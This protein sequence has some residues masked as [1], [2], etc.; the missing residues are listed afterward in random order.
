MGARLAGLMLLGLAMAA[1]A[2]AQM[3]KA[4]DPAGV[5]AAMKAAGF[6]AELGEDAQ[7]EPMISSEHKG[8]A[9]KV[10]FYNCTNKRNCATIQFHSGY[11]V[12]SA[13]SLETINNWNRTQR[14][15]RAFI[16]NVGDPILQMDLDLDDGGVSPALFADNLEFW[17]SVIGQFEKHI[18]FTK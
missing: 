6:T 8:T 18:G 7:G 13:V 16:D 2:G 4:Q 15:G 11:D 12:A 10:L 3:V 17:T 1:P 9:F 5:A 14:F